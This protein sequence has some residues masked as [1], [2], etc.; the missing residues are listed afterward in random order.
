MRK[1]FVLFI[2]LI[3]MMLFACKKENNIVIQ[4][5]EFKA[6]DGI[7]L[8][9]TLYMDP[10]AMEKLPGVVLAH[11]YM[12]SRSSWA[13]FGK[14]LANDGHVVLTFDFRGFGE[15][16]GEEDIPGNDKDVIAAVNFL[17]NFGK[18]DRDRIAVAGASMGGMAAV[19]AAAQTQSIKAVI[20]VSSPPSWKESE[21]VKMAG[22][23][24]PRP[25]LVVCGSNDG[26]LALRA[27]RMLYLS[28]K[29]PREWLEIKTNRHGTDIFATPQG[30]ELENAIALFLSQHLKKNIAPFEET[31][32]DE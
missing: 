15:S 6:E 3:G 1:I 16:S 17:M 9:G 27:G 25:I 14:K 7:L 18:V 12:N 8:K 31:G 29:A 32:R 23:I 2:L 5:V 13:I 11:Q 26:H 24:A 10:G 21:P 4:N 30:A 22:Q 20:T 19:N 28:A